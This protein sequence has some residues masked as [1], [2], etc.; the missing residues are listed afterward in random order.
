MYIYMMLLLYR[1]GILVQDAAP[2]FW[3]KLAWSQYAL[4]H[5][6]DVLLLLN[7]SYVACGHSRRGHHTSSAY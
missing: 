2:T 7:P 4:P 6:S 3:R 5:M 1:S